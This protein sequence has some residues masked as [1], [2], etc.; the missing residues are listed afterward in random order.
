MFDIRWG[1]PVKI[2]YCT[3][4]GFQIEAEAFSTGTAVHGDDGKG[5]CAKCAR[6]FEQTSSAL[7]KVALPESAPAPLDEQATEAGMPSM[8]EPAR[9]KLETEI[10]GSKDL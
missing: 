6:S 4:C 1:S 5:Y 2:V 10:V 8:L 9:T 3:N 7:L